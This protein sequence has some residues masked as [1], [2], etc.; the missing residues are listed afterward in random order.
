MYYPSSV[1][2]G[3]DQLRGYLRLCFRYADCW[4]SHEAAHMA[5]IDW[6]SKLEKMDVNESW[7]SFKYEYEKCIQLYVFIS[8]LYF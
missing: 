3:A 7:N 2:K 8:L 5:G 6:D 4:I 1:N